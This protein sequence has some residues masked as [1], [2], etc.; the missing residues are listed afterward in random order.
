MRIVRWRGFAH[1][2]STFVR[3]LR[4][5][6]GSTC[7]VLLPTAYHLL[8]QLSYRLPLQ[9]LTCQLSLSLHPKTLLL[10]RLVIATRFGAS[11]CA[12][13]ASCYKEPVFR[14]CL[15]CRLSVR[16]CCCRQH[17]IMLRA[18]AKLGVPQMTATK[19]CQPIFQSQFP[20]PS[21]LMHSEP[22]L[23]SWCVL[24]MIV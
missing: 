5:T 8:F 21:Q 12:F 15:L 22:H 6:L 3:N 9:V 10:S 18:L 1:I 20:I 23:L 19:C 24:N 13:G 2:V 16:C 17:C 11:T 7:I 14:F 4:D